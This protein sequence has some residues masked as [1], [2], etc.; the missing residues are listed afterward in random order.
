MVLQVDKV[1]DHKTGNG[2]NYAFITYATKEGAIRIMSDVNNRPAGAAG[3][4]GGPLKFRGRPMDV[5]S[6]QNTKHPLMADDEKAYRTL[7]ALNRHFQKR[8]LPPIPM[9][10]PPPSMTE[11]G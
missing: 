9:P 11:G 5:K 4:A 1:Y 7:N 3:G 8:K 10:P 2:K 6:T